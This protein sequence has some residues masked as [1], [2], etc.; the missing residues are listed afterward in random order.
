MTEDA[1]PCCEL[2][3]SSGPPQGYV[4]YPIALPA[5]KS[6]GADITWAR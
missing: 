6:Y 3:Y 5:P 4:V 1:H 2:L